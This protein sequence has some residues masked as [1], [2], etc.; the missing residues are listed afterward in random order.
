MTRFEILP[1]KQ[2]GYKVEGYF[3]FDNETKSYFRDHNNET[4]FTKSKK[5]A[6]EIV[7]SLNAQ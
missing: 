2:T 5:V 6:I 1:V 4:Y 3:I 7:N